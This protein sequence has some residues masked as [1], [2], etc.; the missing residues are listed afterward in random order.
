MLAPEKTNQII[1]ASPVKVFSASGGGQSSRYHYPYKLESVP[2]SS[3]SV[4]DTCREYIV[5]SGIIDPTVTNDE[6]LN[7][8]ARRNATYVVPKDYLYNQPAT[9]ES[10]YDFLDRYE[11]HD[12]Q[13]K[14]LIPLQPPHAGHYDELNE[15]S[16]Y[17]LGGLKN[18]S[19]SAQVDALESFREIADDEYVHALGFGGSLKFVK[20]VRENPELVDSVDLSTHEMAVMNDRL[21]DKTW[22]QQSFEFPRG[23]ESTTV[24]AAFA[25]SVLLEL[26]YMLSPLCDDEVV[27]DPEVQSPLAW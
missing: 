5:D 16:H 13:A 27:S 23:E 18:E 8:A 12:C 19:P 7:M 21:P 11:Q 25:S 3:E 14:P 26:N 22:E 10:V 24:R 4:R 9:T 2:N 15:F 1:N 17:A 20:A 6:I